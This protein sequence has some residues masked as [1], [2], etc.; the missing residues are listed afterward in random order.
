MAAVGLTNP[1]AAIFYV[2]TALIDK[3]VTSLSATVVG[4]AAT[5]IGV[6]SFPAK[7]TFYTPGMN[8]V[9]IVLLYVI[10]MCAW[11]LTLWSR[12]TSWAMNASKSSK[13]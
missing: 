3:L 13:R 4:I 11:A 7:S 10:I 12:A 2:V 1:A 9:G 8:V 6:E 5:M